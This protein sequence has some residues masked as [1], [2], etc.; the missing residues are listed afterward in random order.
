MS[1]VAAA[2][3]EAS[4]SVVCVALPSSWERSAISPSSWERSAMPLA[5]SLVACEETFTDP[6][7][8]VKITY[9]NISLLF[10]GK[11]LYSV[12]TCED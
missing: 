11:W 5:P 6:T 9:P 3:G 1:W 2:Q 8:A 4:T 10:I 7:P 12:S